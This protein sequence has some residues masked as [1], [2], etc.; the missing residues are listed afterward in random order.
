M[1]CP[2]CASKVELRVQNYE[3]VGGDYDHAS[4]HL[5][6]TFHSLSRVY[7]IDLT[8]KLLGSLALFLTVLNAA[9]STPS[10]GKL[11][12]NLTL[13]IH[14]DILGSSLCHHFFLI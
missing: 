5:K 13:L 6:N 2:S 14:N 11:G 7:L 10:P 4:I 12:S 3:R 9:E 1:M 8:M